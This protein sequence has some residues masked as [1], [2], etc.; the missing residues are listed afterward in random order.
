MFKMKI[1]TAGRLTLALIAGT[2][3]AQEAAPPKFYKLDFVVKEVE[4]TKVINARTYSGVIST[5]HSCSIR[6]GSKVP[7]STGNQYT[8][9]D[10]GVSIDCRS[11]KETPGGLTMNVDADISSVLES[12]TPTNLP[13]TVRQNKWASYVV[14]PIKKPTVLFSSDDLTTRHQM[15]VE[16]TATPIP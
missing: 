2:C 3:L 15:Q 13:P 16:V 9:L 4:G 8:F 1:S 6:T 10:V 5:E 11:V 12:T 7:Y 14:V